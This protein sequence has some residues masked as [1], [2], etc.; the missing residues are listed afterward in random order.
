MTKRKIETWL[1]QAK[2]EVVTE[3]VCFDRELLTEFA[4]TIEQHADLVEAKKLRS[5][6]YGESGGVLDDEDPVDAVAEKLVD[7]HERI[8]AD[9]AEHV[10]TFKKAPYEKFREILDNNPPTETAK[11]ASPWLDY[12]PHGA[13]PALVAITCIDPE[14]TTEDAEALREA[15]PESEWARLYNAA[16]IVNR[17][18]MNVPKVVSSTVAQLAS[19]LKSISLPATESPSPSSEGE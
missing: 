9:K 13:A 10:F 1:A 15:L 12:D 5:K 3:S 8:E 19:E 14:M 6:K 4:R 7:L 2:P 18:G 11:A 16:D 17:R